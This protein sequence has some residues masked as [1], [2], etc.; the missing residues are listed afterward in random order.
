[1]KTLVFCT[2]WSITEDSWHNLFGRWINHLEDSSLKYD[3]LL[4]IDDGSSILPDW[5]GVTII[6]EGAMPDT[7]DDQAVI[8]HFN[9]NLGRTDELDYP[10]WYRSYMFAATWAEKY[11][12]DK[13]IHIESD[14]FL[15]SERINQYVNGLESEWTTFWCPRH[16]FP[17]NNIQVIVGES[18]KDFISW[19]NENLPYE[20]YKGRCAEFYTPYTNIVRRF[21]GD[22]WGEFAPGMARVA[23]QRCPPGVPINADYVCQVFEESPCW[24][25]N[26]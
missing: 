16:D 25:I 14:A 9:E 7:C 1:M 4:M 20:H 23:D 18:V 21:H 19:K 17:E 5:E 22:R 8:Y 11:G 3:Q 2:A 24:W 13:I 6:H 12:F 26:D 15:I 10:G